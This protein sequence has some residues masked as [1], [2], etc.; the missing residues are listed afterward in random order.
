V[1]G[2][3]VE[4]YCDT[5]WLT[6]L[7]SAQAKMQGIVLKAARHWGSNISVVNDPLV[8][9]GRT[10]F[11]VGLQSTRGSVDGNHIFIF[12]S[13]FKGDLRNWGL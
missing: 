6:G 1:E 7:W 12:F 9:P 10:T 8:E 5:R 13:S 2:T 3:S 11:Y 4:G